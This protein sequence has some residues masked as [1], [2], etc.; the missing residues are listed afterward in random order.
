M[1]V[2]ISIIAAVAKNGV[3]G[4]DNQLPWRLPEDLKNFRRLTWGSPIIMGRKTFDSIG[5]ALPGRF[6]IVITRNSSSSFPDCATADSPMEAINIAEKNM[7]E[8]NNDEIFIIGGAEIYRQTM[9]L[10]DKMYLT[11]IEQCAE[12]DAKFPEFSKTEWRQ[13]ARTPFTSGENMHFS[14]TTYERAGEGE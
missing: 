6:N 7:G 13:T 9:E 12:G 1:S 5:K 11:E 8:N 10:A 3:I 2:R 14:F 4:A